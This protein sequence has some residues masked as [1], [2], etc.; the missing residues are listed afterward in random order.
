MSQLDDFFKKK[1]DEQELPFNEAHWLAAQ[2][3]IDGQQQKRRAIWWWRMG[4][5]AVTIGVVIFL[6]IPNWTMDGHLVAEQKQPTE[7][8]NTSIATDSDTSTSSKTDMPSASKQ[9]MPA[10]DPV[11]QQASSES[12]AVTK[13]TTSPKLPVYTPQAPP[14]KADEPAVNKTP[15]APP[16]ATATKQKATLPPNATAESLPP[17]IDST[18][19]QAIA[20]LLPIPTLAFELA[21]R[22]SK[23]PTF[24][25]ASSSQKGRWQLSTLLGGTLSPNEPQVGP[26]VGLR[27]ER[28]L[29]KQLG[30]YAETVYR[31]Q[32][33]RR[34]A[35]ASSLQEQFG[36]GL[37]QEAYSLE[38]NS[39]HYADLNMGLTYRYLRHHYHLGAG[40]SYLFGARGALNQNV[41]RETT[42]FPEGNSTIEE[43]WVATDGLRD[44][45]F[46]LQSGYE[47]SLLPTLS[48]GMR[49]Q[50][51]LNPVLEADNKVSAPF[52][53]DFMIK[54]SLW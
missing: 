8:A 44:W 2:D 22:E 39:L 19:N 26:V 50:Y 11:Q 13:N 17:T 21:E 42:R 28:K 12:S 18:R 52:S 33:F 15:T 31:S 20:S 1:L 45:T 40:A 53:V 25:T 23:S 4:C 7:K 36:F 9:S 29:G 54:Y 37:R 32:A 47:Y 49:L 10:N 30:L 51:R 6:I 16:I 14:T 38:A 5:L 48:L 43:G 46:R 24:A 41:T 3:L 34:L 27:L 35:P